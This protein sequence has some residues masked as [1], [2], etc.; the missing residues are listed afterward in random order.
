MLAKRP[1]SSSTLDVAS[2]GSGSALL[3]LIIV[4]LLVDLLVVH[5]EAHDVRRSRGGDRVGRWISIGVAFG[6][7]RAGGGSA[8]ARPASTSRATSSR[9][10]SAIDNVFVWALILS[11][12]KVPPQYQHRV[13]FWGIFGALVLRADLHLRR[14]RADR[15]VRVG[16]VHLRR[17]PA[18]HGGASWWSATTRTVDPTQQPVPDR[19]VHRVVP[20]TDELDGQK[21]FTR[22][23]RQAAGHAAVRGAAAGRGHRRAVRRRLGAGGAGGQPRAVHRVH[24][25]RVRDPRSAVAVLP[26]RRHA[27]P[28]QLPAAGPGDH[29]R[30]RRRQDDHQPTGT[31]SPRGSRCW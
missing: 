30:L 24:L 31:T 3:A 29:P 18:V 5:R 1:A 7:R 13:L 25:E 23:E 16:A 15:A 14:R 19:L 20:T 6:A 28:V 8:A 22:V 4:L 17:V 9:R 26:A 27:R 11:Y 12:F 10:A 21:L 2:L